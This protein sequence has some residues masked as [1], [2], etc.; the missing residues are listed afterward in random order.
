MKCTKK[1]LH[2]GKKWECSLD[3]DH[4]GVHYTKE[5]VHRA[6]KDS[7]PIG[8]CMTGPNPMYSEIVE[9]EFKGV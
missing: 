4:A 9:K 5:I 7:G 2:N 3:D 1:I 6:F 8:T